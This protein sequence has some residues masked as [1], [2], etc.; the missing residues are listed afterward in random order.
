MRACWLTALRSAEHARTATYVG[1]VED[2]TSG[3]STEEGGAQED[4]PRKTSQAAVG[5][6]PPGSEAARQQRHLE[7]EAIIADRIRTIRIQRAAGPLPRPHYLSL[8]SDPSST[9]LGDPRPVVTTPALSKR[10]SPAPASPARTL[11]KNAGRGSAP[12]ASWLLRPSPVR[13]AQS[14]SR[15][16]SAPLPSRTRD[17]SPRPVPPLPALTRSLGPSTASCSSPCF[18]GLLLLSSAPGA[19]P[20]WWFRGAPVGR[21]RTC[22]QPARLRRGEPI[23]SSPCR[24]CSSGAGGLVGCCVSGGVPLFYASLA[25]GGRLHSVCG[26]ATLVDFRLGWGRCL[27]IVGLA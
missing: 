1:T 14:P 9:S 21:D 2:N 19:A 25:L 10:P 12:V 27:L 5:A 3:T 7:P 6:P 15:L 23:P 26:A 8:P 17:A 22:G 13:L 11:V 20:S 4:L 18:C 16:V 24:I